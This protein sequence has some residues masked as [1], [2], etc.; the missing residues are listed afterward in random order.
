[1]LPIPPLPPPPAPTDFAESAL[2]PTFDPELFLVGMKASLSLPTGDG[3]RRVEEGGAP[4]ESDLVR[5]G[6]MTALDGSM[7][8]GLYFSIGSAGIRGEDSVRK[9]MC[10]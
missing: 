5:V 7:D 4:R 2:V 6:M 3:L 10:D 1:M 9:P 8:D